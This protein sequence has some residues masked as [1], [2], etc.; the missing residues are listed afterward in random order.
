MQLHSLKTY[1]NSFKTHTVVL[2]YIEC[3][4][5]QTC[6]CCPALHVH[7]Y[8]PIT[9]KKLWRVNTPSCHSL[10]QEAQLCN[11]GSRRRWRREQV[12][13][14]VMWRACVSCKATTSRSELKVCAVNEAWE[15][16]LST[17]PSQVHC[18][19]VVIQYWLCEITKRKRENKA[20][21]QLN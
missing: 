15:Q 8:I 21:L 10:W 3:R 18:D 9:C 20:K 5:Q 2:T 6:R 4:K 11:Q 13:T 16:H 14:A 19:S 1:L 7:M 12:C 17:V